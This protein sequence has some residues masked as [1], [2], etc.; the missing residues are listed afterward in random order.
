M[1]DEHHRSP[2]GNELADHDEEFLRLLRS[3]HSRGLVENDHRRLVDDALREAHTLLIALGQIADQTPLHVQQAAG[4]Q[5]RRNRRIQFGAR[6]AVQRPAGG[7]QQAAQQA[8][9][10]A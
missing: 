3:E 5:R 10:Q 1:R 7:A 4:F 8:A 9:S 6:H 2:T